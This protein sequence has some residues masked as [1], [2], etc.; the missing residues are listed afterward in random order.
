MSIACQEMQLSFQ[1]SIVNWYVEI[2]SWKMQPS[3][4]VANFIWTCQLQLSTGVWKLGCP[5]ETVNGSISF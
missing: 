3:P 2:E 4:P 1:L 5:I